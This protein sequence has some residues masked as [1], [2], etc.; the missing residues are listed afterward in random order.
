MRALLVHTL[1]FLLRVLSLIHST[2][3]IA[4]RTTIRQKDTFPSQKRTFL[5]QLL[6]CIDGS[7]N[8]FVVSQ[9]LVPVFFVKV[10]RSRTHSMQAYLS[11]HHAFW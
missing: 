1:A 10:S 5:R 6:L 3:S 9:Y 7:E 8:P 11:R 4:R 2:L